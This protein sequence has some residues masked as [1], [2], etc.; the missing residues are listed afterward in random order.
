MGICC[1]FIG[2]VDTPISI[3]SIC[4]YN[5]PT[6]TVCEDTSAEGAFA[7]FISTEIA[8]LASAN[9][10]T[11]HEVLGVVDGAYKLQQLLF[12]H[13]LIV[14]LIYYSFVN[15]LFSTILRAIFNMGGPMNLLSFTATPFPSEN[16]VSERAIISVAQ[17]TSS[18]EGE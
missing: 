11:H 9:Q 14:W 16:A 17:E 6:G 3:R 15:L 12:C 1:R 18:S 13:N 4:P 5:R 10:D 7:V 8:G 2:W